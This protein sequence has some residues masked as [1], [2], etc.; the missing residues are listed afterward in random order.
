MM[1]LDF[2]AGGGVE[3]EGFSFEGRTWS[4]SLMAG[5]GAAAGEFTGGDRGSSHS[6]DL[7]VARCDWLGLRWWTRFTS[8]F[9][10][11]LRRRI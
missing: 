10:G 4:L 5:E 1:R 8:L 9:F 2:C 11:G 3:V 6:S 7:A